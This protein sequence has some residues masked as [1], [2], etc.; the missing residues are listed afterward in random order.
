MATLDPSVQPA[1][2]AVDPTVYLTNENGG[3]L[4]A[5]DLHLHSPGPTRSLDLQVTAGGSTTPR[6]LGAGWVLHEH[7]EYLHVLDQ[8]VEWCEETEGR[9]T[10]VTVELPYV[11]E[12]GRTPLEVAGT[13]FVVRVGPWRTATIRLR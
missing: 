7:E 5:L 3:L 9:E 10:E 13:R 11:V 12:E 1:I 2:T 4:Q 8:A 6:L